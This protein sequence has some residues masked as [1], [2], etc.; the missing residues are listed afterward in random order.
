MVLILEVC[1]KY[2]H[3]WSE[4]G[5]RIYMFKAFV[6]IGGIA[7][8][9]HLFFQKDQFYMCATCNGLPSDISAMNIM[10]VAVLNQRIEL[11]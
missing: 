5:N 10:V 9:S 1:L 6:Y 7:V 3:V 11:Y 8:K 2:T 4:L